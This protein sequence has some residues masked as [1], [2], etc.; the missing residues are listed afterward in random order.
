MQRLPATEL[1]LPAGALD[2]LRHQ[3]KDGS[4]VDGHAGGHQRRRAAE[5]V[6]QH[7][8]PPLSCVAVRP[9]ASGGSSSASSRSGCGMMPRSRPCNCASMRATCSAQAARSS[10]TSASNAAVISA[11]MASRRLRSPTMRVNRTATLPGACGAVSAGYWSVASSPPRGA[12]TGA[13]P[14][15]RPP[16]PAQRQ[17]EGLPLRSETPPSAYLA[18][19]GAVFHQPSVAGWAGGTGSASRTGS[20]S[21]YT[22]RMSAKVTSDQSQGAPTMRTGAAAAGA[23]TP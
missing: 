20:A 9:L 14:S 19:S 18:S 2:V 6:D 13:A 1:A 16:T 15:A 11:R 4:G 3:V 7:G 8:L 21:S 17:P 22:A 5:Q 23:A 10:A 12:G